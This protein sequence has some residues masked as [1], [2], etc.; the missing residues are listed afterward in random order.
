MTQGEI[1]L[2]RREAVRWMAQAMT[3]T[4]FVCREILGFNY[5]LDYSA[6]ENAAAKINVGTGG[7]RDE[8]PYSTMCEF[9]RDPKK[10]LCMMLA[11]RG[12]LKSS[13]ITGDCVS[14]LIANPDHAILFMSGTDGQ[15]NKW[16]RK[17]RSVFE[18]NEKVIEALA[19]E[20]QDSLVGNPWT[21]GEWTLACRTDQ[22]VADPTFAT[23]TLKRQRTG[24]HYHRVYIDDLIDWRNCRSPE[25]LELARMVVGLIQPLGLPG[26]KFIVTGTRYNPGDVYSHID[27]LPGWHKLV[28][29]NGFEIEEG[30]DGLLKLRGEKPLFPHLTKGYLQEKL[31]SMSLEEFCAQYMNQHVA[32]LSKAFRRDWFKPIHWETGMRDLTGWIVTDAAMSTNKGACLS[33]AIV[34]GIDRG[35]RLYLLDGFVGKV[36]PGQFVDELFALHVRWQDRINLTGLTMER[37]TLATMLKNWL[38]AESRRRGIRL[39]IREIPRGG[40]E[41]SKDDRIRRMQPKFR[42]GDVYVVHGFPTHY[43][44]GTRLKTLWDPTG[45]TDTNTQQK[46]PAGELVEQFVQFPFYPLKDIADAISDVEYVYKT[47]EMACYYRPPRQILPTREQRQDVDRNGPGGQDWLRGLG[48]PPSR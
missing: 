15:V 40:G 7:V 21:V 3:D 29:G 1:E 5:D 13:I 42:A 4:G 32:G 41:R 27:S 44:D 28:L 6:G 12:G 18:T 37:V 24:G 25:Q 14:H 34:I 33:V 39:N 47:G 26:T 36:E 31:A 35:R 20:G 17:V 10:L 22:T 19:L 16:S 48:P 11:P 30:A 46:M 43:R 38:E 23:S 45:Y 8:P 9:V 2:S